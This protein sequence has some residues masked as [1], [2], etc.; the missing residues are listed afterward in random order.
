M[1]R[2]PHKTLSFGSAINSHRLLQFHSP[3]HR[4]TMSPSRWNNEFETLINAPAHI[5]WEALVDIRSWDWSKNMRL[6]AKCVKT[7]EPGIMKERLYYGKKRSKVVNFVFNEVNRKDLTISW[8]ARMFFSRSIHTLQ[9]V[10]IDKK[11]TLLRHIHKLRG[12]LPCLGIGLPYKKMN[13]NS[14][15]MNESLKNHVESVH[16]NSLIF[17]I[18]SRSMPTFTESDIRSDSSGSDPIGDSFQG[19]SYWD[20]P[21]HLRNQIISS[22][23]N[24]QLI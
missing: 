11:T 15:C 16:F 5:V 3:L 1:G 14:L 2:Y 20:T 4:F 23:L 7:G 21:R 12:V 18:S 8:C 13:Q 22:Y 24:T 19:T 17:S 9:L 10:P 6:Y